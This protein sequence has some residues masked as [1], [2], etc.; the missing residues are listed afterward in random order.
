M[1]NALLEARI[2][3]F[4]I[5]DWPYE[6]C[7]DRVIVWSLPEAKATRDTYVPGGKILMT[8]ERKA[9]TKNESPRAVIVSAGLA[10]RDYLKSH[11]MGL[12]HIIWVARLSPWRHQTEVSEKGKD[13]D[14]MF[15][16][17]GDCCGSEDTKR[18]MAEGRVQVTVDSEGHH[19]YV[20]D[21]EV[22]P[23]FDPPSYV[24]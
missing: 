7:F 14:F 9:A 2:K 21:D 11:G 1:G 15:L 18:W 23:R 22:A 4:G 19:H 20:F 6:A 16:R 17:A 24:A 12:G 8:D 10:A 5:P 13:V 3:E